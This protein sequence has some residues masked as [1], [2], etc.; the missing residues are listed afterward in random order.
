L[1]RHPSSSSRRR[2]LVFIGKDDFAL[3]QLPQ[4]QLDDDVL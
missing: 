2:W 1:L 4:L 3:F